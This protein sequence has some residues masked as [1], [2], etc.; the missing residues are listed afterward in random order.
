MAVCCMQIAEVEL[1]A[2]T[3]SV[4]C[5]QVQITRQPVD[6]PFAGESATLLV[7][8]N[9]P[10]PVQWFAD[11]EAIA[12]ATQTVYETPA[13]TADNEGTVYSVQIGDCEETMSNGVMAV[14]LSPAEQPVSI[15]VN[16]IGGGANARQ[17]SLATPRLRVFSFRPTGIMRVMRISATVAAAARFSQRIVVGMLLPLRSTMNR[18]V[19]GVR[20]QVMFYQP[21]RSSMVILKTRERGSS[22]SFWMSLLATTL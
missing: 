8:V 10:W 3:D 20:E 15:G 1:L 18:P 4:P 17:R 22:I 14:I 5:G 19:D 13:V 7:E 2:L 6:T 11:G 21:K 16:F 12:G 9:G